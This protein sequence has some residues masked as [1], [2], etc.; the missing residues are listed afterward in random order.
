M[1]GAGRRSRWIASAGC[2]SLLVA[3]H[4]V[5]AC[6]DA[7][8]PLLVV[9]DEQPKFGAPAPGARGSGLIADWAARG[10]DRH[11][12]KD[13]AALHSALPALDRAALAASA[14]ECLGVAD[15]TGGC[16]QVRIG[17]IGSDQDLRAMAQGR[18]DGCVLAAL[19][20]FRLASSYYMTRVELREFQQSDGGLKQKASRLAAYV[21]RPPEE[22]LAHHAI[23]QYWQAGQPSRLETE[24]RA[25]VGDLSDLLSAVLT[26]HR[27]DDESR[28]QDAI[29]KELPDVKPLQSTGRYHCRGLAGAACR[30]VKLLRESGERSWVVGPTVGA[31]EAAVSL[32]RNAAL[33]ST[34]AN[35]AM[36][37]D[38]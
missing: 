10:V 26:A 17:D 9:V 22:V 11:V 35:W 36:N 37:L 24:V 8:A 16:R 15:P 18:T 19:V 28:W 25:S 14:F 21:T 32:D 31:T 33:Y 30:S 23:E 20:S 12:A 13:I 3:A 29:W 1:S 27:N 5:L 4:A 7:R 6:T 34:S 38:F 2:A